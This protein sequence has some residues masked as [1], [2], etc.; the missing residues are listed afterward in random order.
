M[1]DLIDPSKFQTVT[2]PATMV[3]AGNRRKEQNVV[4]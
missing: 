4:R 2:L 3:C 1:N